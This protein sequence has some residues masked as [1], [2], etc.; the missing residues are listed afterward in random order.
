MGLDVGVLTVS[1]LERPEPFVRDFLL[2]LAEDA[3]ED[4]WGGSWEGNAVIEMTR[5]RTLA[6]ARQFAERRGLA[7]EDANALAAWLRALPWCGDTVM[8]HLGW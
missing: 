1:Y 8:L 7:Q 3:G 6:K 5:D 2:Q 4:D